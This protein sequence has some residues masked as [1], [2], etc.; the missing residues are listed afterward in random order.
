MATATIE[1]KNFGEKLVHLILTEEEART[2]SHV[3]AS[4][5]EDERY[6]YR[7][8]TSSIANALYEFYP[9]PYPDENRFTGKL[10]AKNLNER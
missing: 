5:G 2:L 9:I 4:I 10:S 1:K 7:K 6:T 3:L 8:F